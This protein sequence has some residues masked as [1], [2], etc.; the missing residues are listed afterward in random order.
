M[1]NSNNIKSTYK[2][3]VAIIILF[4]TCI[5]IG[6]YLLNFAFIPYSYVTVDYKTAYNEESDIIFIGTSH[7]KCAIQTDVIDKVTGKNSINMCLGGEYLSSSYYMLKDIIAQHTPQKVVYELDYGYWVTED[8]TGTDS[9]LIYRNMRPSLAKMEYF[10][11]IESK[12]DF[13]CVVFPWY[14]FRKEYTM[15]PTNIKNKW[16][17]KEKS[18]DIDVFTTEAQEYKKGGSIY[19][20][21]V[22]DSQ[23]TWQNFSE[24]DREEINS[25]SLKY[26][27]KLVTL[28]KEKNIELV[29]IITP[30]AMET[31][32]KYELEYND[33]D[34]YFKDLTDKYGVTY[35]NYNNVE[36]EDMDKS[37]NGFCDYEGHMTG[38]NAMIFSEKLGEDIR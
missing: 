17:G 24:W 27:K 15:I 8:Y 34:K 23:K 37:L 12:K 1:H 29:V 16:T 3:R 6:N 11:D 10:L 18:L 4:V 9:T 33:M 14:M 36:I 26:F 2:K 38:E 30:V 25:N 19:R 22:T 35:I 28:C 20:Y 5:L 32:D 13:R 21:P 7:G 31:I